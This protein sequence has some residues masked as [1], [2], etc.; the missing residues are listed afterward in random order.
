MAALTFSA[1]GLDLIEMRCPNCKRIQQIATR[2][3]SLSPRLT[4]CT[5][6]KVLLIH[7]LTIKTKPNHVLLTLDLKPVLEEAPDPPL[8]D[9]DAE[10]RNAKAS[11]K[12]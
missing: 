12:S 8:S 6:C 9:L 5:R 10:C 11:E 2:S 7:I 1:L 3:L 4:N